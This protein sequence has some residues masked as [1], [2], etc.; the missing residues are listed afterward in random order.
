MTTTAIRDD[1][2]N[3]PHIANLTRLTLLASIWI[4][5]LTFSA[6]VFHLGIQLRHWAWINTENM[7]FQND[8]THAYQ[9]GSDPDHV[10]LFNRYRQIRNDYGDEP[11]MDV[12]LDYAPLRLTI[13]TLWAHW[14]DHH[15]TADD[16][17]DPA[18]SYAFHWPLLTT[19]AVCE[20]AAAVG[21]VLVLR[22]MRKIVGPDAGGQS[23]LISLVREYVPLLIAALLVWFNPAAILN[24]CW[25]QWD[26]WILPFFIFALYFAMGDWWF[27]AGIML[28]IGA[29]LKGQIL[30][31]APAFLLWSLFSAQWM[32]LARIVAGFAVA[33]SL[34]A[35][36]WTLTTRGDYIFASAGV[37]LAV[38]VLI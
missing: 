18:K 32:S 34:I 27:T 11:P 10:G 19:N 9:W 14:V 26:A 13:V 24:D 1:N 16:E 3:S 17:W 12:G 38:F 35:A 28:G 2:S 23:G 31:V 4:I 30:F 6:C 20:A 25:P 22:R 33:F 15:F 29:M 37:V 36:P 5:V 8:V 7:H 21:V